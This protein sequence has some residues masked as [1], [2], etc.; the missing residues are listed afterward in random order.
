MVRSLLCLTLLTLSWPI[1]RAA[2][3]T[4]APAQAPAPS[5]VHFQVRDATRVE[6]WRFFEPR[7]GGG[8][9]DYAFPANR[10]F[11]GVDYRVRRVDVAA[12]VQY[13]QFGHLPTDA[14]GPGALGTGSQYF[15]QGG[16]TT[17]HQVYLRLLNIK[18]KNVARGVSVQLGR[19]GYASGAESASG[20]PK[21]E[22]V[23]R[24]RVD[25]RLIGEF[26]WSLYQ[27]TFDGGRLD[28]DRARWHATASWFQPTQGGFENQAGL[29]LQHLH[30]AAATFSLRPGA[31]FR[32]TDWQGF[33]YRYDDDR[34][35]TARPDNTLSAA[36]AVDV[37]ITNVGTT[38][39]G[40]SDSSLY[41]AGT[42]SLWTKI[43]TEVRLP[44]YPG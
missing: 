31:S 30:L 22:A 41:A 21:I 42:S 34:A 24:Q 17:S 3:Q 26:E 9:P 19:F 38:L 18:L 40:T 12:G 25:S 23:K 44:T 14:S 1:A 36:T 39:V 15:D 11:V 5:P 35:V 29:P 10:L 43:A 32:H 7:A 28:V 33:V 6:V 2:G 16:T 13:V 27:R 4:P 20:D 37:H 8:N